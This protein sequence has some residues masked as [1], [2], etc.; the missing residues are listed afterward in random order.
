MNFFAR[1]GTFTANGNFLHVP[2]ECKDCLPE[3]RYVYHGRL[4]PSCILSYHREKQSLG[5][6]EQAVFSV[7]AQNRAGIVIYQYRKGTLFRVI[8]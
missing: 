8:P 6:E 4:T 5:Q 1:Y 2:R 3:A 7:R